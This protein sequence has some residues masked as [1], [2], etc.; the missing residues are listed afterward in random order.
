LLREKLGFSGLVLTDSLSA[1]AIADRGLTIPEAAVDAIAAGADMI[2][3]NA[4]DAESVVSSI[5][6]SV[7]AAVESGTITETQ[8]NGAVATVVA[9][10]GVNLCSSTVEKH[11]RPGGGFRPL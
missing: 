3:F 6:Q 11:T 2:L 9:T 4:S 5:I 7:S 10:K 8:L 1:G